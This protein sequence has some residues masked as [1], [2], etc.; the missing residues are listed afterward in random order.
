MSVP[1]CHRG[2]GA[3]FLPA[4]A[5]GVFSA[6]CWPDSLRNGGEA[7]VPDPNG[8]ILEAGSHD[9]QLAADILRSLLKER[10][11]LFAMM[12]YWILE[13]SPHRR[14]AQEQTLRDFAGKVRWFD[15]WDA[16]PA[17]GV[18]GII[19]SNELLDALPV[20]RLGW[21][22]TRKRWFEWGV[23]LNGNDFV[24]TKLPGGDALKGETSRWHLPGELLNVLPDGFTTE[25]GQAAF[26]WWRRAAHFLKQGKLL[27]F[28]YGLEREEFFR[29]ERKD[30]TLRAYYRHHLNTDL[31]ARA[32]EQDLTAQVDFTAI[33]EAGET[34]GL[35]TE[36]FVAQAGFLT[37]IVQEMCRNNPARVAWISE[38]A[39]AFQTLTHPEHLGRSFRVLL[40]QR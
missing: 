36:S 30:G 12:E 1:M 29:P 15:S 10:P 31:L 8:K 26:K 34:A 14:E 18:R 16:L 35:R 39:R 17:T 13:P 5:S 27:A 3:T 33:H 7:R 20:R 32:G 25:F 40:Q 11:D 23:A 24:W 22:A 6:N 9:G 19:F 37:E 2:S 4:S 21:D 28:D 38:R